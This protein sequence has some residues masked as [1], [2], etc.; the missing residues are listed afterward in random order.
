MIETVIGHSERN[1]NTHKSAQENA[2]KIQQ[3]E[4]AGH[5]RDIELGEALPTMT[6][7][8][9]VAGGAGRVSKILNSGTHRHLFSQFK[10]ISDQ[11]QLK[12]RMSSI[13]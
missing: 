4:Q 12:A 8:S 3:C 1:Q 9:G 10:P 2:I 7:G 11:A 5:L 13:P 6:G